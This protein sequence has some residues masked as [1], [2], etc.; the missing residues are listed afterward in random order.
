MALTG[1]CVGGHLDIIKSLIGENGERY[2]P[3][4]LYHASLNGRL[5]IVKFFIEEKGAKSYSAACRAASEHGHLDIVEYMQPYVK[6]T[7]Y[8]TEV[9]ESLETGELDI[10]EFILSELLAAPP[11]PQLGSKLVS[12]SNSKN[13]IPNAYILKTFGQ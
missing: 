3:N 12:D 5:D 11:I 9:I 8:D 4:I 7:I 1:A 2:Y 10:S 13:Q 6:G